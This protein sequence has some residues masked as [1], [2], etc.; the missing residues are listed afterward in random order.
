[1][2]IVVFKD[3]LKQYKAEKNK[4]L[5]DFSTSYSSQYVGFL[6][7]NKEV[8]QSISVESVQYSYADFVIKMGAYTSL[9]RQVEKSCADFLEDVSEEHLLSW[10][11][12]S[13]CL[14]VADVYKTQDAALQD[15][16]ENL[17]SS[18]S[19]LDMVTSNQI[20]MSGDVSVV[21]ASREARVDWRSESLQYYKDSLQKNTDV[22]KKS[23][24][25]MQLEKSGFFIRCQH[26]SDVIGRWLWSALVNIG[27]WMSDT[28]AKCRDKVMVFYGG[29]M[30]VEKSANDYRPREQFVT[31]A[32]QESEYASKGEEDEVVASRESGHVQDGSGPRK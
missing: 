22:L 16:L 14:K 19:T 17:I 7:K 26:D 11:I 9:V 31:G 30:K 25:R 8:S 21:Q 32:C 24:A 12:H 13:I 2:N 10:R 5:E 18:A 6:E 20:E 1:M 27:R 29:H 28:S 15:A 3:M 23:F 4:I